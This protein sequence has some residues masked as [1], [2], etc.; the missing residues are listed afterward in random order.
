M[1]QVASMILKLASPVKSSITVWDWTLEWTYFS[2]SHHMVGYVLLCTHLFA[3]NIT[4]EVFFFGMSLLVLGQ[5]ALQLG[6]VVT[7]CPLDWTFMLTVVSSCGL[8][9]CIIKLD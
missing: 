2:M 8:C 9:H 4:G 1:A 3:A 5:V 7:Y 6:I